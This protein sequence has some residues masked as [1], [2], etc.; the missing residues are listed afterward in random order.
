MD[1][2][3]YDCVRMSNEST[4]EQVVSG[5]A[6]TLLFSTFFSTHTLVENS[7]QLILVTI[8]VDI[9]DSLH[10]PWLHH[11]WTMPRVVS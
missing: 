5:V 10:S 6:C 1:T 7:Y 2:Y 9:I 4:R 3:M 8:L 11:L